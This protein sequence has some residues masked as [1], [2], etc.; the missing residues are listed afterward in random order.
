MISKKKYL[1]KYKK[2]KKH[3]GGSGDIRELI[4]NSNKNLEKM[5]LSYADLKKIKLH[6]YNFRD[7][8]LSNTVFID[9]D[10]TGSD[11]TG[12]D[13]RQVDFTN[14][15]LTNVNF[16]NANLDSAILK[17][18]KL[19]NTNLTNANFSGIKSFV[20]LKSKSLVGNPFN[21]H[22]F[23]E[24]I[25][26]YIYGP[27]VG[28][29]NLNNNDKKELIQSIIKNNKIT[30]TQLFK[31]EH[32]DLHYGDFKEFE[33]EFE[34]NNELKKQFKNLKDFLKENNCERFLLKTNRN[35]YYKNGHVQNN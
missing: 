18:A 27:Y 26:G 22:Q 11:F 8:N 12:A 2:S 13:L 14:A 6:N 31:K 32:F 5:D 1:K 10:L 28:A 17:K 9:A 35:C 15:D 24:I 16:T 4:A 25:G 29:F 20:D 21:I 19:I 3:T 7:S 23:Y 33:K 34:K 30:L